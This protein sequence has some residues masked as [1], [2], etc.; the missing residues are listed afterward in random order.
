[1][2]SYSYESNRMLI[3]IILIMTVFFLF[4]RKAGFETDMYSINFLSPKMKAA[5]KDLAKINDLTLKSVYVVSTGKNLDQAL[6]ANARVKAQLD[7]LKKFKVVSKFS[8]AGTIL[9]SDSIQRE[10]I[11]RWKNYWT[12]EKQAEIEK[13]LSETGAKYG[14]NKEAFL[15]FRQFVNS[16]FQVLDIRR[17]DP[18]RKLFLNDM[19]TE[20]PG[21]TMVISIVKMKD[22]S[23]QQVYKSFSGQKNTIVIDRQ[24]ITSGFVD[25]VRHDFDLLVKLCLIFVTLTLILSFG[26][27]ETGIIAAVPMFLSWLWTLGFMGVFELKFNIIN[28]IVSTFVFG[29]GSGLQHPDDAGPAA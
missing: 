10:R 22:T 13:L 25:H 8:N 3:A 5:E 15:P 23:R 7:S 18:V 4:S 27:L 2:A 26:R 14:F 20:M 24:E 29:L 11:R 19:I 12:A 21:L 17:F 6:A 1:M 16:D 28:I 9:I